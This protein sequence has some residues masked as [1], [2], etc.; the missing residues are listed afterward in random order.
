VDPL[1]LKYP[2]LTAYQ[3][4]SNSPISG[5][6]MDGLEYVFASNGSYMGHKENSNQAVSNCVMICDN[7]EFTLKNEVYTISKL[8]NPKLAC[9]SFSEF[10]KI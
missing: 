2:M 4:A 10:R 7:V 8:N 1:A 5:V 6:D 3:F 9:E